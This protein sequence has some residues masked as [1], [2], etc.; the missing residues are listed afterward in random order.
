MVA[1]QSPEMTQ[2]A[3]EMLSSPVLL[4]NHF[5]MGWSIIIT[6]D[7]SWSSKVYKPYSYIYRVIV[8]NFISDF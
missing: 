4:D 5:L 3:F 1:D 8:K 2:D 7:T 6:I